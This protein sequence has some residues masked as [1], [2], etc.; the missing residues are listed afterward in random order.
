VTTSLP[1][2]STSIDPRVLTKRQSSHPERRRN[3]NGGE[4]RRVDRRQGYPDAPP[5]YGVDDY[6]EGPPS[7][8]RRQ[9]EEEDYY[10]EPPRRNERPYD[11]EDFDGAF[12]PSRPPGSDFDFTPPERFHAPLRDNAD[13]YRF[14]FTIPREYD[15]D[16]Q[17]AHSHNS[18]RYSHSNE[19]DN[20][21]HSSSREDAPS[22]RDQDEVDS[23]YDAF[24]KKYFPD[25]FDSPSPSRISSAPR[26]RSRTEGE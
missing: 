9:Q 3:N 21:G 15:P 20:E 24:V 2:A 16:V 10:D 11:G 1:I 26:T 4:F 22:S 18:P 19:E 17:L 14:T 12:H 23:T 13:R 6:D 8:P 5:S 25:V 7:P